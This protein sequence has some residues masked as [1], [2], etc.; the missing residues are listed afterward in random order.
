MKLKRG[1]YGKMEGLKDN[2]RKKGQ[3]ETH[4]RKMGGI[5]N[6]LWKRIEKI[7]RSYK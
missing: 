2:R 6:E 4:D 3:S 5:K 7:K 1:S